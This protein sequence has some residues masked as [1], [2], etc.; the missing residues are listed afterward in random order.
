MIF[1]NTI[2]HLNVKKTLE[3]AMANDQ[4]SHAYIFTGKGGVGKFTLAYDFAKILTDGSV[5]DII[6]PDNQKFSPT[7]KTPGLSVD[8]VRGYSAEMYTKPYSAKKKVFIF[9]DADLMDASPQNALLKV[10]EEPPEY[11]VIILIAQNDSALLPTICSRASTIRFENLSDNEVEEVLKSKGV[12]YRP[13]ALKLASGSVGM[14][15]K[16]SEDEELEALF[17]DFVKLV[18]QMG[19]GKA[20]AIYRLIGYF[21]QHSENSDV[22]FDVLIV[23]IRDTMVNNKTEYAIDGINYRKASRIIEIIESTRNSFTVNAHYEMAVTEM[24]LDV[25]GEING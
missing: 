4:V 14:A 5:A 6:V 17:N 15:I 3:R 8:S 22:L 7:K 9:D 13:V 24:L 16:L 21:T 2:G 12:E 11:C 20:E 25:L 23:M 10:F 18:K 19:S 1:E